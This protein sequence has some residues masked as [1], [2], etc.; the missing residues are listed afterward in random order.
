MSAEQSKAAAEEKKPAAAEGKPEK[1]PKK[2]KSQPTNCVQCN[3]RI[4]R[5]SWYYHNQKYFCG[6]NCSK[7]HLKKLADEKAKAATDAAAAAAPKEEAASEAP[8]AA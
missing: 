3:V 7:A 4:R 8:K 1:A 5:K 6:P 2:K